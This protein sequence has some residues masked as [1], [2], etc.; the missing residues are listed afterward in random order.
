MGRKRA[1]MIG[2]DGAD[3][4]VISRMM[5]EGRLPNFKKFLAQGVA[6][7]SLGMLGVNPTVTPPNWCSLATGNWPRTH[8]VTDFFSHTLGKP[9]DLLEMNWDSRRVQSEMIWE[10]FERAGKKSVLL[11]YCEAWPP[12][13]EGTQNIFVDGTSA[14]PFLR[15]FCDFQKVAEFSN[16]YSEVK[17]IP[18][19][20]DPSDV[21]DCIVYSDQLEEMQRESAEMEGDMR[22]ASEKAQ[23]SGID[24][25][26]FY[27]RPGVEVVNV[28]YPELTRTP[29][30]INFPTNVVI[31]STVDAGGEQKSFKAAADFITAPT[32]DAQK[33]RGD[34]PT[35]ALESVVIMNSGLEKRFVLVIPHNGVYNEV[36]MYGKKDTDTYLGSAKWDENGNWSDFIYDHFM[37]NETKTRVAYRIRILEMSPD[38][39]KTK[40][41]VGQ[42]L[43]MED[44]TYFYPE[45]M[46]EEFW[47][48]VGPICSMASY[49][50]YEALSDK[51]TMESFEQ[52]YDWHI[53]ATDYLLKEKCPDWDLFYLHIHGID[54]CNHWY[55]N[56]SI[57][58]SHPQWE[59]IKR[60]C[61]EKMYEITDKLV[62]YYMA[63]VDDDT[64]VILTSDHAAVPKAPGY[65]NPGLGEMAALT[66]KAMIDLGL[67]EVYRDEKGKWKIDWSKTRAMVQ[68]SAHVYIN[69]KGR[70]PHGIVEPEDY[71]K[72][73]EEVIS[74]LYSYRDPVSGDRVVSFC[75]T[76]E[77]MEAVGMGGPHCGDIFFQV[78]PNFCNE[79]AN[80]MNHVTNFGY[81]LLCLCMMAGGGFKKGE[82][83]KRPIRLVDIV[84]T[85]CHLCQAPMPREV[86]GGIIYQ[87]IDQAY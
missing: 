58:G 57:P 76:R 48:K 32:K 26:G 65:K 43:T 16:A 53:K 15:N 86:E 14:T 30:P 25:G 34:V 81:S 51:V 6:H 1:M 56:E 46:M 75:M 80:S 11:N 67:A 49:G 82:I 62:G 64:A 3:P 87:A 31:D 73:V 9:L 10:S 23:K 68:R 45:S 55:I 47:E 74:K 38:G 37:L 70:E 2:L 18:H 42:A 12:R 63:Y 4:K 61:I 20:M 19:Y 44:P 41:F 7:D 17:Y 60:D 13:V 40:I 50:R 5:D 36:A 28:E 71:E 24:M 69:L 54:S 29:P 33:W 52:I 22:D 83:I 35:G 66:P 72:T 84:P 8:G 39:S 27:S 21:G 78:V 59:R 79:H 85:I 77:E